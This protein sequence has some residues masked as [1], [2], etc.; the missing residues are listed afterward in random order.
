MCRLT[1]GVPSTSYSREPER[2]TPSAG[3]DANVTRPDTGNATPPAGDA[4]TSTFR[5]RTSSNSSD[6]NA[7][8]LASEESDRDGG[9]IVRSSPTARPMP[10]AR[11]AAMH[12]ATNPTP[13][14]RR[15]VRALFFPDRNTS[16]TSSTC[17]GSP[18]TGRTRPTTCPAS[19]T[20]R[21]CPSRSGNPAS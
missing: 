8:F 5:E 19:T 4:V 11:H 20:P 12:A 21:A 9:V 3:H 15:R 14:T 16:N 6:P 1:R 17:S 7:R 18:G 2:T 13:F 10:A